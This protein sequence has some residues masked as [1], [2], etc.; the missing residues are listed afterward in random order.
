VADAFGLEEVGMPSLIGFEG[1]TIRDLIRFL[2]Q[3]PGDYEIAFND[4]QKL[5][6]KAKD[7]LIVLRLD[8]HDE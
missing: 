5:V 8:E 6:A 4:R 3:Y 2:A 7:H 1:R